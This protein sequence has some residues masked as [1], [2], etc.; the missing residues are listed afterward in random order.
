MK[1]TVLPYI[2]ASAIAILTL[3][4]SQGIWI[5]GARKQKR[6]EQLNMFDDIF[7]KA[8]S[9]SIF[10][11]AK[12]SS[13]PFIE[14][15]PVDEIPDGTNPK[16]ITDL[17]KINSY[18]DVGKMLENALFLNR[19]KNGEVSLGQLDSLIRERATELG[20][21][22]YGQIAL[23][24]ANN[25]SIDNFIFDAKSSGS[26]LS[27]TLT[28]ERILASSKSTYKLQ[29]TYKFAEQGILRNMSI[30]SF[31]SLIALSVIFLVLFLFVRTLRRRKI[32]MNN[33]EYSFQGAIHDL[34]SPLAYVYLTL[35]NM[36]DEEINSQKKSKLSLTADRVNFLSEKIKLMLKS[37]SKIKTLSANN[38][39]TIHIADT[40]EHIETELKAMFYEKN[41]LF[42]HN[43]D[44]EI[45]VSVSS[46]LFEAALR[47]IMENAVKYSNENPIITVSTEKKLG[48]VVISISDNGIG[49]SSHNLKHLFRPYYTTDNKDGSGIGLYYAYQI[50]K[51]HKGNITVK[52]IVGQGSTF[53]IIIPDKK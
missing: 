47:I 32:E 26:V 35:S 45:T 28:A 37:G 20:N 40:V 9:F 33:M 11:E 29:A 41:I 23:L 27:N 52:S 14:V 25:V 10:K 53:S 4:I 46:D 12:T 13:T 42:E 17:G 43:M 22:I 5:D 16:K 50:I 44:T 31:I 7:N 3:V 38:F 34:K 51:A 48:N 24:D 30:A 18:D 39:E 19:L 6:T 8:V 21:V 15:N 36:E 49:V 2:L 1:H